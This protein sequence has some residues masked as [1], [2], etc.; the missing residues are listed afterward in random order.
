[1]SSGSE[2]CL[3][4]VAEFATIHLQS[5]VVT[6]E[7]CALSNLVLLEYLRRMAQPTAR[8]ELAR[9]FILDRSPQVTSTRA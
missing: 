1:M 8:S 4:G 7:V 3:R 2:G 9:I 5:P 6:G